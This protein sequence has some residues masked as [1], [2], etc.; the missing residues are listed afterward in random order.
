MGWG[1]GGLGVSLAPAHRN[2]LVGAEEENGQ[3]RLPLG[4]VRIGS[5]P[6]QVTAQLSRCHSAFKSKDFPVKL[7]GKLVYLL[8]RR[9]RASLKPQFPLTGGVRV[10]PHLV[11]G[12]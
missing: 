10:S 5:D 2:R 6:S 4:H 12:S 1:Q 11:M 3:E 7:K 8:L 9:A